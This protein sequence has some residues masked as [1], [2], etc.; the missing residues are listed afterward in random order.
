M[1]SL[2]EASSAYQAE[3][4][5]FG[6]FTVDSNKPFY[7]GKLSRT[8]IAEV[9]ADSSGNIVYELSNS[10]DLS[11]I[12]N[13]ARITVSNCPTSANNGIKIITSVDDGADTVTVSN[14]GVNGTTETP[15]KAYASIKTP[16]VSG[17]RVRS[18][19]T[20]TTIVR[21]DNFGAAASKVGYT[22]G[23]SG[24]DDIRELVVSGGVAELILGGGYVEPEL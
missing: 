14:Q 1:A 9:T 11:E 3:G 7:T 6:I 24:R 16:K 2:A 5:R 15:T 8:S 10:P 22:A 13:G 18:D 12:V 23:Y 21:G 19:L 20:I 4:A 17:I